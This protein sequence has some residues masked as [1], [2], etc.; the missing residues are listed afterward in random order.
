MNASRSTLVAT[1]SKGRFSMGFAAINAE[2]HTG[3]DSRATESVE[4]QESR[5][6]DAYAAGLRFAGEGRRTKAQV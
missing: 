6:A 4:A 1:P 2:D 5:I 3:S